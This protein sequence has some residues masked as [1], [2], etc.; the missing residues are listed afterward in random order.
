MK[1]KSKIKILDSNTRCP[2]CGELAVL[3]PVKWLFRRVPQKQCESCGGLYAFQYNMS[4]IFVWCA[5]VMILFTYAI[6]SRDLLSVF[7]YVLISVYFNPVY[8]SCCPLKPLEIIPWGTYSKYNIRIEIGNKDRE[9]F[10][11]NMIY[12][13]CFFTDDNKCVS[14][15]CCVKMTEI[16]KKR[17]EFYCVIS[18]LPYGEKIDESFIDCNFNLFFDKRIIGTGRIV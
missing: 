10:K 3:P 14:K 15:Y 6:Y 2:Y 1:I 4:A 18:T 16:R 5:F 8:W 12:P 13:I 17:K 7:G 11:T 9:F